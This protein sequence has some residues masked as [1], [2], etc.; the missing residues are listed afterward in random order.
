MDDEGLH[1]DVCSDSWTAAEADIIA[2]NPRTRLITLNV[3]AIRVTGYY[4]V[5][6]DRDFVPK[7]C[8][9]HYGSRLEVLEIT[10]FDQDV[11]IDS[12]YASS[13]SIICPITF[14]L[15]VVHLDSCSHKHRYT[16][17]FACRIVFYS[18]ERKDA[19][20]ELKRAAFH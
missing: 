6:F 16:R 18:I 8:L 19:I 7:S 13:V 9:N 3:N 1:I 5:I 15:T 10:L 17:Y 2:L 11:G 4:A 20:M 14:E 12:D